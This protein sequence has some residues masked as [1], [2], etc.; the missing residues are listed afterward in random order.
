MHT[1][2]CINQYFFES[3]RPSIEPLDDQAALPVRPGAAALTTVGARYGGAS[4]CD[5][6]VGNEY[7]KDLA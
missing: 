1:C 6:L 4:R 7:R 3:T 5:F 2:I